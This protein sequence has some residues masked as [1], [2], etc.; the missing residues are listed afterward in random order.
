VQGNQLA[1]SKET[2]RQ[3]IEKVVEKQCSAK[4]A[5]QTLGLLQSS[6]TGAIDA[7]IDAMIAAN[8]PALADYKSGK[9]QARG[10]LIGMVMKNGKGL[11]AKMV[12]ERLDSKLGI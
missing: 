2:A 11:N 12:G 5:A 7:A 3:V 4:E 9:K 8:P 6:D 10:A 1:A